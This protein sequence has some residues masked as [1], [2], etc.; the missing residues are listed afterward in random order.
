M[1][2]LTDEEIGAYT[3]NQPH[4][5]IVWAR[6]ICKVQARA[7]RDEIVD[8]LGLSE[9]EAGFCEISNHVPYSQIFKES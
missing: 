5:L 9:N 1:K 6:H 3:V 7:T 4:A 2:I 8:T